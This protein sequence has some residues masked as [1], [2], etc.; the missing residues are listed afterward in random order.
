MLITISREYGAGGS[1]VARTV[2]ERLGWRLVDNE[3]VEEI[4]GRAA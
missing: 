2:A 1:T 4:G 3:L